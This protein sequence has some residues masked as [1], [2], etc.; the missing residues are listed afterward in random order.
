[1]MATSKSDNKPES[2]GITVKKSENFSEWYT[3]LLKKAEIVD[4][5]YNVKG[6]TVKL[7]WGARTMKKMYSVY[8]ECLEKKGHEPLIMPALIPESN[9]DLESDH[10][11]GFQPQVYWVTEVADGVKLD[12]KLALRPTSETALYRMYSQWI[13]SYKDLPFKRYQ[14]CQVW[15]Y[16][17]KATR[18]LFRDREFYWIEAHNVFATK[19]DAEKQIIE[20]METTYEM[21]SD[22][23]AMP[24]LFFQRPE[25]DKFAGAVH[26]YAADVL[27]DSGKVI[28]LPSTHFL[29]TNFSKPFNVTFTDQNGEEKLGYITCYGPAISRIYG[30]MLALLGD[31]KGIVM[32][33]EIAPVQVVI[34]PIIFRNDLS[35]VDYA[36]ELEKKI[37]RFYS[38]RVDSDNS[39]SP[40]E[41][42]NFWELKG[43]PV[44]IEVGPRELKEKKV[45]LALRHTGEK[46]TVSESDLIQKLSEI[47]TNYTKEVREMHA[48][49]FDDMVV[50]CRDVHEIKDAIDNSKIAR[51]PLCSIDH[52]GEKCASVIETETKG[53]VRGIRF[54][55]HPEK[56][57]K[58]MKC[59]V[60]GKPAKAMVYVA[61]SY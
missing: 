17:G 33:F 49:K 23:F 52:D 28:Q 19:E 44:R 1:M 7:P 32:P 39:T 36:H 20:D 61:R 4:I 24:T 2:K 53:L 11:K 31:D 60:C 22:R 51:C 30:A 41:K 43:V 14:S 5:R 27:L 3:Q 37:A 57:L 34:V 26:T 56:E 38:V 18:P 59:A 47:A 29:G 21:L 42:F 13:R 58:G 45:T 8:E 55:E 40:G 10:V 25:W 9:F 16:E 6:M 50:N 15:R 48:V 54:D 35:T 46:I 12:E